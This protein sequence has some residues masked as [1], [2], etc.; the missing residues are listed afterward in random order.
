MASN[1]SWDTQNSIAF[2]ATLAGAK[3]INDKIS[4]D[5]SVYY[6]SYSTSCSKEDP[7]TGYHVPAESLSLPN[8]PLCYLMGRITINAG[9][10][11]VTDSNWFENDGTV[12]TI[13]M[14]RPFTGKNGPEPLVKYARGKRLK[15]GVWNYMGNYNLDHK[16]FIG[17]FLK[18]DDMISDLYNRFERHARILYSLP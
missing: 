15:P 3:K 6:F 13:S 11:L 7:K 17:F 1:S 9:D 12:N 16:N 2:D 18:S 10:G 4:I 8:Y 5:P 14:V